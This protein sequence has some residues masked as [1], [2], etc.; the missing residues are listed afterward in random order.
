[1]RSTQAGQR[2]PLDTKL[3]E[4]NI[5]LDLQNT[6]TIVTLYVLTQ[7]QSFYIYTMSHQ[8]YEQKRFGLYEHL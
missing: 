3:E 2:S 8:G 1:M 4:Y 6:N 5:H 7:I